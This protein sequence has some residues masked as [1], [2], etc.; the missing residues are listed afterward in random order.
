MAGKFGTYYVLLYRIG[1][2]SSSIVG[3]WLP[4]PDEVEI[5]KATQYWRFMLGFP[6]IIAI[7]QTLLLIF[8]FYY[9]TP[10]F[11]YLRKKNN[12]C[13]KALSKI[14]AAEE[15]INR[16]MSKLKAVAISQGQGKTEPSWG[17][18]FGKTYVIA[19]FAVLCTVY[20]LI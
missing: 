2:L 19:L 6:I 3:A 16:V 20:V 10:K 5:I 8:V 4:N 7:I 1:F 9:E 14:Y 11:L 15:D 13:D 18:L 17:D 12:T